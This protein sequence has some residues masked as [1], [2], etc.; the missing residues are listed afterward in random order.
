MP[1]C[2]KVVPPAQNENGEA[3]IPPVPFCSKS[4]ILLDTYQNDLGGFECPLYAGK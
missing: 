4:G 2:E 1:Y 3:L